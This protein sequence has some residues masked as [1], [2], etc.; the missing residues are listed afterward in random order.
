[1]DTAI[2][3]NVYL[4]SED[5]DVYPVQKSRHGWKLGDEGDK[6]P[7][8]SIKETTDAFMWCQKNRKT[9]KVRLTL[10]ADCPHPNRTTRQL[11]TA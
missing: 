4:V 1:M 3:L 10:E 9:C 11:Q 6:A 7:A 2:H 8:L 5:G